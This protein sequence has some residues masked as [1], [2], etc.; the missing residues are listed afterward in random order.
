MDCSAGG[1]LTLVQAKIGWGNPDHGFSLDQFGPSPN[2]LVGR[3]E[4]LKRFHPLACRVG[5]KADDRGVRMRL[6]ASALLVQ[7]N[8]PGQ[9]GPDLFYQP[10][11]TISGIILPVQEEQ[12]RFST[13]TGEFAAD[14]RKGFGFPGYRLAYVVDFSYFLMASI[15]KEQQ[16]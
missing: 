12:S 3:E 5:S 2:S 4:G 16:S 13:K 7:E 15:T 6:W 9:F 8:F 14:Q 10:G 1:Q 11:K